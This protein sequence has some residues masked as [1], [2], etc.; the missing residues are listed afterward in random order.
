MTASAGTPAASALAQPAD[1]ALVAAMHSVEVAHRHIGP[2]GPRREV[3]DILDR[4]HRHPSCLR[5]R[6]S[7]TAGLPLIDPLSI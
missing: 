5:A 6:S 2:T 3:L 7:E 1:E 4:D